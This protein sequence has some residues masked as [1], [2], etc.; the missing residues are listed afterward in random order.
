MSEGEAPSTGAR[1]RYARR[2]CVTS[3]AEDVRATAVLDTS[4]ACRS[5]SAVPSYTNHAPPP[6][7]QS[8]LSSCVGSSWCERLRGKLRRTLGEAGGVAHEE[9][10]AVVGLRAHIATLGVHGLVGRLGRPGA[11][12]VGEEGLSAHPPEPHLLSVLEPFSCTGATTTTTT[13]AV[14][15]ST[16]ANPTRHQRGRR[17]SS[18]HTDSIMSSTVS[19]LSMSN[20][21]VLC[22]A[23][24]CCGVRM[25]G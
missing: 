18:C 4:S 10:G 8:V 13:T 14:S 23:A 17:R 12:R 20:G 22:A 6:T 24:G 11:L 16:P 7:P 21:C 9:F 19:A 15:H 5:G 1:R 25:V 2:S 3:F